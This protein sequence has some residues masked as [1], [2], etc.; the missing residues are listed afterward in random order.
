MTQPINVRLARL[1]DGRQGVPLSDDEL[2]TYLK[3]H[4]GNEAEQERRERHRVRDEL[5]RDGGV[6]YMCDV[7]DETFDNPKV[8]ELRKKWV[9]HARFSNSLKRIVGEMSTV[10]AEPA[11]RRVGGSQENEARFKAIA[12]AVKIDELLDYAN[13][14][15]NLH[16]AV[17]LGPRVWRDPDDKPHVQIDVYT[18]TNLF[19]LTDPVNTTQVIGWGI[20]VSFRTARSAWVREP[21]W[22]LWTD[23]EVLYLDD[24]FRPIAGSKREHGLGAM[25]L[26]P[27]SYNAEAIPGFWPGE[28]GEDLVAAQVSIWMSNVLLLKETKSATKMTMVTGDTSA[29]ARGQPLDT[30]V[31][32]EFPEGVSASAVDM[33]MDTKLFTDAGDHALSHAGANYGLSMA[34]LTHQGVQSAEARIVMN[35]PLRLIRRKQIKTFRTGER[36]LATLM[37]LVLSVDAPELGFEV[38]AWKQNFGEPQVLLSPTERLALFKEMRQAGL[39]STV[40]FYRENIDTDATEEE[41]WEAIDQFIADETTR[42]AKM[43]VLQSLSGG[44]GEATPGTE[45]VTNQDADAQREDSEAAAALANDSPTGRRIAGLKGTTPSRSD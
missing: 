13:R 18:P 5:Y 17:V 14:M 4:Y 1:P 11:V 15:L 27:L 37:A 36:A 30:D 16:R 7:I 19:A 28:E 34:Q 10:Y 35:E 45:V 24:E 39:T 26:L 9:K 29:A 25:P 32:T 22:Q 3:E 23:H 8:R 42:V 20:R 21:V 31:P 12:D 44:M 38:V 6:K 43:R 40:K 2:G 33:S 41:A